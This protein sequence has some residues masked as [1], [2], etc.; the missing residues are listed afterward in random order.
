[1]T[2]AYATSAG[3]D[4]AASTNP[5]EVNGPMFGASAAACRRRTQAAFL[6]KCLEAALARG[7]REGGEQRA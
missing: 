4:I 3:G 6:K 2:A 7:P 5:K 1:M